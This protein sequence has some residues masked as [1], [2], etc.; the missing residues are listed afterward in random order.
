MTILNQL[1]RC[2]CLCIVI[3]KGTW[4]PHSP[5]TISARAHARKRYKNPII[6]IPK[7]SPLSKPDWLKQWTISKGWMHNRSHLLNLKSNSTNDN[8]MEDKQEDNDNL[9]KSSETNSSI[10]IENIEDLISIT[11]IVD[12]ENRY[13]D[14]SDLD[15]IEVLSTSSS[16]ISFKTLNGDK[17]LAKLQEQ[18]VSKIFMQSSKNYRLKFSENFSFAPEYQPSVYHDNVLTSKN[19]NFFNKIWKHLKPRK[20][21]GKFVIDSH[22]DNSDNPN[23]FLKDN[24][25]LIVQRTFHKSHGKFLNEEN[26]TFKFGKNLQDEIIYECSEESNS[27][28]IHQN[29]I[30]SSEIRKY[31]DFRTN[32][33]DKP[34]NFSEKINNMKISKNAYLR[35]SRMNSLR[36]RMKT[37]KCI[38]QHIKVRFMLSL[39]SSNVKMN[40][41]DT[42]MGYG[43]L[44][45][46]NYKK[47]RRKVSRL[48]AV[49]DTDNRRIAKIHEEQR[50]IGNG[51][52]S[53]KIQ[54]LR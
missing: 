24:D 15:R 39:R 22:N 51:R 41:F 18:K 25:T 37:E 21:Y 1:L 33:L 5:K 47:K 52:T 6:N 13:R 34:G 4:S 11:S 48:N 3:K 50:R 28:S 16:S 49:C 32:N 35:F 27:L 31:Y 29:P 19:T 10:S 46:K 17:N 36:F 38:I 30:Y 8:S 44:R 54:N 14:Q 43:R 26:K 2:L 45:A 42:K 20:K 12:A 9:E 53:L 40:R 23:K 7:K